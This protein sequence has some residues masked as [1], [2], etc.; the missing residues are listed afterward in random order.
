MNPL[1]SYLEDYSHLWSTDPHAANLAWF[2]QARFGLFIHYGLYSLL[3]AGEWAQFQQK[4]PIGEYA[5][6]ADRFTAERFNADQITDLACEARMKYVTLVTC[7]HDSFCLWDS[8]VE[9]FNSVRTAARRDLVAEMAEQ[10]RKKRL[11][12]FVYYTYGLNWRHPYYMDNGA[13]QFA[14]PHYAQRPSEYRYKGPADF[15]KYV[16]Y[17]HAAMTELLTQYGPLAGVWLDIISAG[18]AIPELLPVSATYAMVRRLQ[19]QALIA[20]KQG[21]TGEEDFASCEFTAGSLDQTMRKTYGEDAARR[22]ARAWE[23]NRDKHNEVCSTLGQAWGWK[24]GDVQKSPD[25]VMKLLGDTLAKRCNLLLNVG[26]EPDGSLPEEAIKTLRE[27]GRRINRDGWPSGESPA[28][29]GGVV[30]GGDAPKAV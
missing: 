6:L 27:V 11:G 17:A 7:H 1:P 13:M 8:K 25:E 2:E 15:A 24:S 30:A 5:K 19:P 29:G 18:Y 10:C 9:P 4:I 22:A 28:P 14:R 20:F 16:D 23:I 26:P 12:F 3:G 21:A